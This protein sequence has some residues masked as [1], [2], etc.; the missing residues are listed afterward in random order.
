[1][2]IKENL[3]PK[4]QKRQSRRKLS[5]GGVEQ[6]GPRECGTNG[7]HSYMQK[8]LQMAVKTTPNRSISQLSLSFDNDAISA[9]VNPTRSPRAA[10]DQKPART[11][12]L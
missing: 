9:G 7:F 12:L 4:A 5:G 6:S 1:M 2:L 10:T 11:T 8:K 3:D